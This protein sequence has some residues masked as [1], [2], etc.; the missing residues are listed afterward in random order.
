[1]LMKAGACALEDVAEIATDGSMAAALQ[2]INAVRGAVLVALASSR[3]GR[4]SL[5][6][7]W[8]RY[9]K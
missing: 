9:K 7:R 2:E 1:M 8:Q 5:P 4:L 3:Q 6:P